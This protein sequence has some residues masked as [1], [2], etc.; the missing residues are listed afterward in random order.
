MCLKLLFDGKDDERASTRPMRRTRSSSKRLA[1][2]LREP[3][4]TR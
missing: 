4:C 3:V 2:C 1:R